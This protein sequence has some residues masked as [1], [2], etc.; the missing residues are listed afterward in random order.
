MPDERSSLTEASKGSRK[1]QLEAIRDY[2]T[3]Q[4][5]GTKCSKCQMSELRAGEQTSLIKLLREVTGELDAIA[6]KESKT[7][8]IG[9]IRGGMGFTPPVTDIADMRER[10]SVTGDRRPGGGRKPA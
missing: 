9:A 4:L 6:V 1:E 3:D 2:I 8:R 5:E 10:R 7:G